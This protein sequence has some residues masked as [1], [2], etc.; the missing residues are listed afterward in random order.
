MLASFVL[1]RLLYRRLY[2]GDELDQV[3]LTMGLIFM[4]VGAATYFW[5]PLAQPMQPPDA[6][7]RPDRSGLGRRLSRLP[8]LSHPLRRGA[9]HGAVA[10]ARAHA[11]RGADARRGR[12]SA[13][14]A[15]RSASIPRGCLPLT[16]ALGSGLAALGGALGAEL[17][18][19]RTRLC[20]RQPGLLPDRGRGRRA[21]QHP[22][23]VRRRAAGRH[24]RYGASNTSRPSSAP[25]SSTR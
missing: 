12:Q 6:A 9:G 8:Q 15:D 20:A 25:S 13:H 4:S 2:G 11:L 24:R 17:L 3:L 5:G 21:R 22:R 16:F 10:G 1:E 7:Q 18:G 23:A 19:D 14:G